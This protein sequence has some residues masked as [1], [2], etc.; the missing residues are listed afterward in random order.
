MV[1]SFTWCITS[2]WSSWFNC[3]TGTSKTIIFIRSI[4][5][6]TGIMTFIYTQIKFTVSNRFICRS[7]IQRMFKFNLYRTSCMS[8]IK[9][10]R[11]TQK[12]IPTTSRLTVQCFQHTRIRNLLFVHL[13]TI[14]LNPGI[15]R[16]PRLS[17]PNYNTYR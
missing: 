1:L 2:T 8:S 9:R 11:Q 13:C 3:I 12:L 6:S 15:F 14:N 17:C 5:S 10:Y 4:T 16:I 7:L